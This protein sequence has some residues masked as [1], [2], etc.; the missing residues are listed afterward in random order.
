MTE[1]QTRKERLEMK[2]CQNYLAVLNFLCEYLN[3]KEDLIDSYG[4]HFKHMA[5]GP[6]T[7]PGWAI[8]D[9]ADSLRLELLYEMFRKDLAYD[10]YYHLSDAFDKAFHDEKFLI[11]MEP[12]FQNTLNK[13]AS[14][15]RKDL[16]L[17]IGE[18][19]TGL[20]NARNLERLA[21]RVIVVREQFQYREN[22]ILVQI[23]K[24]FGYPHNRISDSHL[25][26]R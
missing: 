19:E 7:F 2:D 12:L 26:Q 20:K 4:L 24:A 8:L 5:E 10:A 14:G 6:N 22:S 17:Y 16:F 18:M 1:L 11:H 23:L 13:I 15:Y 3:E 25:F 21:A 9:R